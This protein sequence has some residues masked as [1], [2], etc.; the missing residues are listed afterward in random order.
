MSDLEPAKLSESSS[1]MEGSCITHCGS[2]LGHRPRKRGG[3]LSDSFSCE[4]PQEVVL[5]V[6]NFH[7]LL[8]VVLPLGHLTFFLPLHLH[9]LNK[10]IDHT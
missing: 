9:L 1:L 10:P 3:R 4:L 8:S 5:L 7:F 6:L 2:T